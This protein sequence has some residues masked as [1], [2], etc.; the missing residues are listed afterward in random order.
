MIAHAANPTHRQGGTHARSGANVA[1][2]CLDA[3]LAA[4]TATAWDMSVSGLKHIERA[5]GISKSRASRWSR[6]GE[7]NPLY[8]VNQIVYKLAALG[9]HP[10]AIV[11]SV[12]QTL[13]HGMMSL[14]D[15]ALVER[16]WKLMRLE[17]EAQGREDAASQ[18]F[19]QTGDLGTLRRALL[20]EAGR[21]QEL[22]AVALELDQRG[23]DP[24]TWQG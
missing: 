17:A 18:T 2:P 5:A 8:D 15:A 19:A 22:A 21:E 16:F 12:Y 3:M 23:I 10:G 13:H 6:E 1:R 4:S 24:R 14:S 9:Q 20:D 11:A 7:G